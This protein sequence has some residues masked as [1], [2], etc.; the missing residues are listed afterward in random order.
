MHV[1]R[2]ALGRWPLEQGG[3]LAG[4]ELA[5]ATWGELDA[6]GSNAILVPSY[7][8][9]TH[10]SY[11]PWVGPGRALDPG[12]WFV[13]AVDMLGNGVSTSPS[14]GGP[15]PFPGLTVLDQVRAQAELLRRL[16]VRS[17][18][19]VGGWSM[20]AMQALRW[21][22]E[23]PIPV[24]SAFS[25]CGSL[26]CGPLNTVFLDGLVDV[27]DCARADH[28]ETT[29]R[30]FGSMY[31][32]WAYSAEF[33]A[34]DGLADLGYRDVGQLVDDWRADHA[35]MHAGDLRSMLHTWRDS[36]L[37]YDDAAVDGALSRINIP[38]I[39]MPGSTDAYF[40]VDHAA[41]E[42]AR[43]PGARVRVLES[44]LGHIAGRPGVRGAEDSVVTAAMVE[45]L[46][47]V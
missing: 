19:M 46:E 8:T 41:D 12:R 14:T 33:L 7:F 13:V 44:T 23:R 31:A 16:G 45:L 28:D 30:A 26:T 39:V 25:L 2:E 17:L 27:L 15:T 40:T 24:R 18:A 9:G 42:A 6:A 3:H 35:A 34:G 11:R 43:M 32:G 37:G 4:A 38:T 21:A 10:E 47:S 36:Y 1:A 5:Y 20:G 29:L 22:A